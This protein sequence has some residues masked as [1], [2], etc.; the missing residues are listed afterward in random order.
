ML[1]CHQIVTQYPI[2]YVIINCIMKQNKK[3]KILKISLTIM[4]A[5]LIMGI[6]IYLVPM[7]KNLSTPIGQ[8]KF[9]QKVD[10]SGIWGGLALFGLQFAQ[11]F[12]FILPGEP[13]EVLAGMCYGTIWGCVFIAIS[14]AIISI[15]IILLVKKY[16][17]KFVYEF[18]EKEKIEKIEN[19]RFLKNPEKVELIMLILF[20][21]P[22]TPK[23]LLVYLAGILPIKHIRFIFLSTIARIPSIITSTFAGANLAVGDWKTSIKIYAITFMAVGG[24]GIIANLFHFLKKKNLNE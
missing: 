16:G 22:G 11:I 18:A 21:I 13:I 4:A 9:K 15:F 10:E 19:S 20:L 23:D 24:I 17:R 14:S 5:I 1:F 2:T 12:L 3:V 6:L 8:A 7:M